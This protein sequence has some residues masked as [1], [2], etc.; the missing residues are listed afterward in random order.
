MKNIDEMKDYLKTLG[1][2]IREVY[3][4]DGTWIRLTNNICIDTNTGFCIKSEL[5]WISS[6]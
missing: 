2:K 4:Y 1:F 5:K 6:R 3:E